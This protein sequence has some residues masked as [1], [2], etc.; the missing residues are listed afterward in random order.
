[1]AVRFSMCRLSHPSCSPRRPGFTLMEM[2]VVISIITLLI[3]LLLPS[4]SKHRENARRVICGNNLRQWGIMCTSY[5]DEN[6]ELFPDVGGSP[7]EASQYDA[8]LV[9][10]LLEPHGLIQEMAFCI[11]GLIRPQDQA[12]LYNG[13]GP[14]FW[15]YSYFPN[16]DTRDGLDF[17][18]VPLNKLQ[19][20][21]KGTQDAWI[22]IADINT[23]HN[24]AAWTPWRPWAINHANHP[25]PRQPEG[26]HLYTGE[27]MHLPYGVNNCY[28]DTSVRWINFENLNMA[29]HYVHSHWSYH[30]NWD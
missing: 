30:H 17:T 10:R 23:G 29:K 13:H 3:S 25:N 16:R 26:K 6:R 8:S 15:G 12:G 2:L 7:I 9:R 11:D 22:L 19:S 4:L 27:Q 24:A 14:Q 18:R 21:V 28:Y 1:M 5:S 20:R